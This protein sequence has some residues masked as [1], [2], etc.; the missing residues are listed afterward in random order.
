MVN[1]VVGRERHVKRLVD[2]AS[3]VE[4]EFEYR[5]PTN[6]ERIRY[7]REAVANRGRKVVLK[8]AAA[9]RELVQTLIQG[10]RFPSPDP[11][12]Q[13]RWE[14][15][16]GEWVSLSCRPGDPGYREDWLAILER[17]VPGMLEALGMMVFAGVRDADGEIEFGYE[18]EAPN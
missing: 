5:L 18:E 6:N 7:Q 16:Q 1:I 10:F 8:G 14:N 13:I 4:I 12:T 3:G 2:Q 9:A 11:D 15:D 17:A